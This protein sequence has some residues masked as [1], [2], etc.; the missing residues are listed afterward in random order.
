MGKYERPK[1]M[2]AK[3]PKKKMNII[4]K[5]FLILLLLILLMVS[6]VVGYIW[7]KLDLIQYDNEI[8]KTVYNTEPAGTE[9]I[10]VELGDDG[11]E[12]ALVDVSGLEM[13]ETAPVISDAEIVAVDNVLNVLLIGTDERTSEFNTNARSDSMILVSI[14]QDKNTVKL[15]SLERGMAAP[16][17]EG[18][19]EGQ[20]DWLTHVF[21]YGG[22]DLLVKTVEHC[23]KVEIDHY[24]RVNF[25]S[26]TQVVD[27][28]G[29]I[30]VELTDKEASALNRNLPDGQSKLSAG[31][32][33]MNGATALNFARLRSI[34]SDWRRV[35]RQRQ[36]ILAVVN[37]LK[38]SNLTKLNDLADD[39]L[40]L[41]QTN[42]TKMEIAELMLYAPNFL[43]ASFDQMTLPQHGTYGGME[44]MGGRV[45]Y[46]VDFETNTQILHEFLYG[47]DE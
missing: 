42:M 39:V 40:P 9:V 43:Q 14:D 41:I 11:E 10:E 3:R 29:G 2:K 47:T 21:R 27:T 44:M 22:A 31:Q 16:I 24:V 15:V 33:R 46:A 8:D 36:V 35:T 26:V 30:T 34:D 17:L 38:G 23:F 6:S 7:L 12:A 5:I 13:V 37:E 32:N 20:Y 25:N 19:Y 1:A 28:I 4:L 45:G 18:I